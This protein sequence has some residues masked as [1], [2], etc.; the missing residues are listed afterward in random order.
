[1]IECTRVLTKRAAIVIGFVVFHLDR[2]FNLGY[3]YIG[4]YGQGVGQVC[5]QQ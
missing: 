3:Y 5:C 1:M 2:N 4:V